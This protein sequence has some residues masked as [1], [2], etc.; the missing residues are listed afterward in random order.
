VYMLQWEQCGYCPNIETIVND[1]ILP[2]DSNERYTQ[3]Q[4]RH[5]MRRKKCE[6]LSPAH[7]NLLCLEF[8]CHLVRGKDL[9]RFLN[10]RISIR[11]KRVDAER[12]IYFPVKAVEAIVSDEHMMPYKHEIKSMYETSG[13]S[14]ANWIYLANAVMAYGQY[15]DKWNQVGT[16]SK[17]Y[18]KWVDSHALLKGLSRLL[19]LMENIPSS[20]DSKALAN[21]KTHSDDDENH[22]VFERELLYEFSNKQQIGVGHTQT[23][24][25]V[26][27]T[28]DWIGRGLTSPKG[29]A[30]DLLEI[31]FVKELGNVNR[32]QV[33]AYCALLSLE[34]CCSC[35]GMIYNS[36]TDELEICHME[37]GA[38][39]D[40]L[41]DISHFKHS[42]T[43]R[44]PPVAGPIPENGTNRPEHTQLS[45]IASASH[46]ASSSKIETKK[47]RQTS[48]EQ[49]RKS[50]YLPFAD[51]VKRAP[52]KAT[53][54]YD[55]T[56]DDS[57]D[58][59]NFQ[60][61]SVVNS[62]VSTTVD[63]VTVYDLTQTGDS[64]DENTCSA[65]KGRGKYLNQAGN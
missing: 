14:P 36:R 53:M 6:P 21:K 19:K 18:D 2:F 13:K 54:L 5:R 32:L 17:L 24:V 8:K 45:S 55:L 65:K 12:I 44:P 57:C 47:R 26:M 22:I 35:S 39:S 51:S 41:L 4:V 43:R 49:K 34:T 60:P 64:S 27:G 48:S 16:E 52:A 31:K 56:V 61:S 59:K 37:A 58:S 7:E 20:N 3:E 46:S 28:C 15:H 40:F 30:V 25:G 23:V 10:T 50:V 9:I 62:G 29:V 1:G 63:G 42:G 33:L 38:A 11:K